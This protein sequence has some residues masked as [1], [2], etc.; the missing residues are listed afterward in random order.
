MTTGGRFGLRKTS[1]IDYPGEVAAVFFTA[2]CNLRCPYCHNP[3]LVTGPAPSGFIGYDDAVAFLRARRR[4]I[5]AIVITGGEPLLHD[6]TV[7][8]ADAAH[9]LGMLVKLDTNGS[10]PDR[11]DAVCADYVALDIKLPPHR[12]HELGAPRVDIERA[13]RTVREAAPRYE[14]R[15]TY[16]PTMMDDD[17]I[18]AI[19]ALLKPGEA[20][21]VTA[22]RPGRTLDPRLASPAPTQTE[23]ERARAIATEVGLRVTVRDHRITYRTTGDRRVRWNS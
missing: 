10:L 20:Y 8:L 21:T 5:S 18:R 19:T 23:L 3:E 12:Y 17:D 2:G 13:I 7:D 22:F 6:R 11:I 1:L 15:T 16:V 4:L 14:F 9:A